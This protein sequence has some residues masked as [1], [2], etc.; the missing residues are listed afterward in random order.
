MRLKAR[1]GTSGA[2]MAA[3]RNLAAVLAKED[4]F[5]Y[6][7][8]RKLANLE[9]QAGDEGLLITT[10]GEAKRRAPELGC[11]SRRNASTKQ[12]GESLERRGAPRG[13][14]LLRPSCGMLQGMKRSLPASSRTIPGAAP[15][16]DGVPSGRK[17]RSP[18]TA[19][20]SAR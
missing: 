18:C 12:R 10:P 17:S 4:R 11:S 13:S 16:V 9:H 5:A 20:T 6:R 15:G 8:L 3:A 14:R 19:E 7:S 2:L 1:R